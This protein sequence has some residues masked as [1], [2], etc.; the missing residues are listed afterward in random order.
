MK[1]TTTLLGRL[2]AILAFFRGFDPSE[3]PQGV[4]RKDLPEVLRVTQTE[5]L[6]E[7]GIKNRSELPKRLRHAVVVASR[8]HTGRDC[9]RTIVG[10]VER[11]ARELCFSL[12]ARAREEAERVSALRTQILELRG[13]YNLLAHAL[14]EEALALQ[15]EKTSEA[16]A[17]QLE[18]LEEAWDGAEVRF[19]EK[20]YN[21]Y[22]QKKRANRLRHLRTPSGGHRLIT[23]EEFYAKELRDVLR[24]TSPRKRA[25]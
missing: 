8:I 22:L 6:R 23:H 9:Y 16:L 15:L 1:K 25:A 2:R 19:E 12:E 17:L 11:V 4:I 20:V 21:T 13:K 14:H 5:L 10:A 3:R 18:E 7:F 24:R